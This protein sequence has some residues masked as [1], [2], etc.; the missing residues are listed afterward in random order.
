MTYS[1]FEK[2]LKRQKTLQ[3]KHLAQALKV[4]YQEKEDQ[5]KAGAGPACGV[6]NEKSDQ[7]PNIFCFS[8]RRSCASRDKV[9]V[10]RASKR[11]TPM[12]SPVSSQ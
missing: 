10:G 5:K 1:G 4:A 2:Y 9:A 3:M 11:P 7:S 8:S 12:A 6:Q